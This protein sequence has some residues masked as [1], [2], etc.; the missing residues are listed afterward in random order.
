MPFSLTEIQNKLPPGQ[1]GTHAFMRFCTGSVESRKML[2]LST[3]IFMAIRMKFNLHT[4]M[5]QTIQNE[6]I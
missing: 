1:R 3:Q 6:F 4:Q 2:R 5:R